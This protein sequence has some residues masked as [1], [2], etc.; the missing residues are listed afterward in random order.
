MPTV[1]IVDTPSKVS[2]CQDAEHA[3]PDN[4]TPFDKGDWEHT[5]PNC[6]FMT[7]FSIEGSKEDST[8]ED[9]E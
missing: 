3:P 6:G 7:I 2:L 1:K 9:R 4:K 5:C 8:K